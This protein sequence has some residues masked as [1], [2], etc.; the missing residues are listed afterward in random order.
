LLQSRAGSKEPGPAKHGSSSPEL[1]QDGLSLVFGYRFS[2]AALRLFRRIRR[3]LLM[4]SL[5]LTEELFIENFT[6]AARS[7]FQQQ[8]RAATQK[9]MG[10]KKK[11][12]KQNGENRETVP[13]SQCAS[14]HTCHR[15]QVC[16]RRSRRFKESK[17][18]LAEAAWREE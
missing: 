15:Q 14:A 13:A 11:K 12:T 17:E 6:E 10:P 2:A 1:A 3:S 16:V 18:R 9:K 7:E 5:G 8:R 4:I